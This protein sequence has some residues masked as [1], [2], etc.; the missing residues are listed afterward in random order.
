MFIYVYICLYALM[1][2]QIRAS[3]KTDAG[4][5]G[6]INSLTVEETGRE[7]LGLHPEAEDDVWA[8]VFWV[9]SMVLRLISMDFW[10]ISM[11]F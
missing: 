7:C 11:D 9:I 2:L 4:T 3:L 6:A 1:I 8:V 10:V 5:A